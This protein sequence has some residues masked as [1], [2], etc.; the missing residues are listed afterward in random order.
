MIRPATPDDADAICDI[1][2][3]VVAGR[4]TSAFLPGDGSDSIRSVRVERRPLQGI[5]RPL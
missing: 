5:S 2:Q 4:D 3:R 1:V